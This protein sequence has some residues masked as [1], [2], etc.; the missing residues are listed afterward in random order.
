MV[1]DVMVP[2]RKKD[3]EPLVLVTPMVS[4]PENWEPLG[5]NGNR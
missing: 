4:V 1:P 2:L 3:W 5:T